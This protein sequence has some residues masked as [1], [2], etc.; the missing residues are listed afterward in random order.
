MEEKIES[1]KRMINS[2]F[3]YGRVDR[4]SWHFEK[5]ISPYIEVLG[6][7]LFDNVYEEY[8]NYLAENFE[9]QHNVYTDHEGCSYNNLI[10]KK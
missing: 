1:L 8:I 2:C 9:V 10:R 4:D 3:T 6:V 7:E 5:Y